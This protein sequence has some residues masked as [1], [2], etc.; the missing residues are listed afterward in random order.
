VPANFVYDPKRPDFQDRIYDVY[1][2]LR[3][4]HPVYRNE[5]QGF[6]AL[7]RFADV[8]AAANDARTFSSEGHSM[9]VGLL[10]HIQMMDPPRHDR[11][12]SLVSVAFTPRRVSEM[13]PRVR[14]IA[15]ELIDGFA[16]QG[17]CD[18]LL[19]FARH[20]PSRVIGE[21]IG[22]P[23]ERRETFLHWTEAMVEVT[24]G[25]SQ[26]ETIRAPAE[27]IYAEFATILEERRAERRDDLMSALL[28]A[29]IDGER[30]S[31]QE[32]LGFCFVLIVAGND[33]TTNLIANGAVLLARAPEQRR[34]L[35]ADP[36]LIPGAVEEMLR[37]ESPAQALPRRLT[38]DVE[39]HGQTLPAG[40]EL[41]LVWGAA[42]RDEREF[43]NPERFDVSRDIKRQ[44]AFGQGVHFCLGSNLARLEARVAFEEL[45]GRI[46]AYEL[47][48]E[49]RWLTSIWARALAKVPVQFAP[50]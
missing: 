22:V 16:A 6:W 1:R 30:L 10:P 33:T 13:E 5:E 18:L 28:D 7:S 41:K 4:R 45:L 26:A 3:D 49:P 34:R 19:D 35:S 39:L 17:R 27:N 37:C 8:R 21:L 9:A 2:V 44:L 23:P 42:N 32:L 15:R 14:E 48:S 43:E 36:S 20:L 31:Q 11:L 25:E 40:S 24:S 38:R 29:E 12:R 50:A 47:S 46:P